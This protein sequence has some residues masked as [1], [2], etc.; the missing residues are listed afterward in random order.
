VEAAF[1]KALHKLRSL[2][3][4]DVSYFDFD[5]DEQTKRWT[6]GRRSQF[7][8]EVFRFWSVSNKLS[9]NAE[10]DAFHKGNLRFLLFGAV[11][12]FIYDTDDLLRLHLVT[13]LKHVSL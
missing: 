5:L 4:H 13:P 6:P 12:R 2:L 9:L 7:V 11:W 3:V 10:W 1:V 8:E